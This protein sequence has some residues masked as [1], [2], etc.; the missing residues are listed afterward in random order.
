[1]ADDIE[2]IATT[3]PDDPAVVVADN[4]AAQTP[5]NVYEIANPGSQEHITKQNALAEGGM[6]SE[7]TAAGL[8]HGEGSHG[9]SKE[10]KEHRKFQTY[11][12][13]QSINNRIAEI[14]R[15]VASYKK[16]N[17]QLQAQVEAIKQKESGLKTAKTAITEQLE[18][19]KQLLEQLEQAE[20]KAQAALDENKEIY[21]EKHQAAVDKF[22]EL[23]KDAPDDI[24]SIDHEVKSEDGST[25]RT[26]VIVSKD[27]KGYYY[28]DPDGNRVDVTDRV[29]IDQIEAQIA[30]GKVTADKAT[31]EQ[32]SAVKEH[33]E[34]VSEAKL[35]MDDADTKYAAYKDA[36]TTLEKTQAQIAQVKTDIAGAETRLALID[37]QL[38]TL[39]AERLVNEEQIA[40][41]NEK[42]A[43]LTEERAALVEK[44]AELEKSI[45]ALP[46]SVD[47]QAKALSDAKLAYEQSMVKF[48]AAVAKW[49]KAYNVLNDNE[50]M[51]FDDVDSKGAATTRVVRGNEK[52][53]YYYNKDGQKIS[54]SAEQIKEIKDNAHMGTKS[55]DEIGT[56]EVK[57][58]ADKLEQQGKIATT[59]YNKMEQLAGASVAEETAASAPAPAPMSEYQAANYKVADAIDPATNEISEAELN[60]ILAEVSPETAEQIREKLA[61]NGTEIKSAADANKT[62]TLFGTTVASQTIDAPDPNTPVIQ[63]NTALSAANSVNFDNAANATPK[64]LTGMGTF[65]KAADLP[66]PDTNTDTLDNGIAIR[67]PINAPIAKAMA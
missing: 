48:D 16:Q 28:S 20:D 59:E 6:V 9:E 45:E 43:A 1:M 58:A 11:L 56:Q 50:A 22:H 34:K 61:Q 3:V 31:P 25:V 66:A 4:T 36:R 2:P 54:L 47:E 5:D 38:K 46:G 27:D 8:N 24:V 63:S 19:N 14:D 33:Q 35:L 17:A 12:A 60:E 55:V 37:E 40:A 39:E 7:G 21:E 65:A 51:M 26:A 42:I 62:F 44:K 15:Q 30:H 57:D 49:D 13:L 29:N 10:E 23:R 64:T 52:D 18:K 41:N 32:L 53:G 67:P